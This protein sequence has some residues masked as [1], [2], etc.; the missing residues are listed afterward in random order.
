MK[1]GLDSYSYHLHFGKHPDFTP[2][3]P[4]DVLWFLERCADIGFEGCQVDSL[5]RVFLLAG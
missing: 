5:V 4:V 2:K 3:N 1:L